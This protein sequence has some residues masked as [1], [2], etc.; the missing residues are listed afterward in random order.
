MTEREALKL[1]LE[2]LNTTESDCGSRAWEREQE[3]ITAIKE[4]LAQPERPQNCGT[5]YCS[6]IECVMEPEPVAK[7][8]D[9]VSDGGLDPRKTTQPQQEL[10]CVCGAV[11]EGQ[12]LIYTTPQRTWVGLTEEDFV[13]VNQL[14]INPIDAAEF[15]AHL[16][17]EKNT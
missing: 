1:A 2:A 15:V 12:E 8:S 16:L 14:C 11:W 9:I 10:V 4:A 13:L 17:K 6:C 3:A 7:Y 5:G